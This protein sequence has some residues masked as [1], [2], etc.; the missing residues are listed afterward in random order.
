MSLS[1]VT[2]GNNP[3]PAS[4]G[5]PKAPAT[6]A[7]KSTA[8]SGVSFGYTA[9]KTSTPSAST[10]APVIAPVKPPETKSLFSKFIDS[11][12]GMKSVPLKFPSNGQ[13][14]PYAAPLKPGQAL[15]APLISSNLT[16]ET[17]QKIVDDLN[18][19]ADKLIADGKTVNTKDKNAVDKY[20]ADL[21]KF[22]QDSQNQ[23]GQL[24]QFNMAQKAHE[25]IST[26]KG[27]GTLGP[28]QEQQLERGL[29]IVLLAG[30]LLTG[31]TEGLL[32]TEAIGMGAQGV[33]AKLGPMLAKGI[34][35]GAIGIGVF[36]ALDK[37]MAGVKENSSDGAKL[38]IYLGEIFAAGG[39]LHGLN[40][41]VPKIGD[42]LFQTITEKY[43][44]PKTIF[45]D[46]NKV[47]Q[48]IAHGNMTDADTKALVDAIGGDTAKI[49]AA[50]KNG[51]NIEIPASKIKTIAESPLWTKIKSAFGIK[52]STGESTQIFGKGKETVRGYLNERNEI[53]PTLRTEIRD[54]IDQ[55]GEGVTSVALQDNLGIDAQTAH[56]LIEKAKV[57]INQLE[58]QQAHQQVMQKIAPEK[59]GAL[60][61][62]KITQPK[63]STLDQNQL[64]DK[65]NKAIE[66]LSQ[67]K[68]GEV[69]KALSHPEIGDIDLIWGKEPTKDNKGFGLAKIIDTHPDV[70]P[71]ISEK[72]SQATITEKLPQRT[73]LETKGKNPIR[74][75]IDYQ[76]GEH[77]KVFLNNAYVLREGLEPTT[78][79][80]SR[81]RST[82]ELP[83]HNKSIANENIDVNLPHVDKLQSSVFKRLAAEHPELQGD[84]TYNEMNMKKDAENAVELLA[85]DKEKAFRVAMGMEDAQNVTNTAVNIAMSEQA[86]T[87]GNN[88]LYAQ[89]IKNRSLAQ[90]RRGQEIVAEKGSVTDNST[91]RYV[92]EL[93]NARLELAGKKYLGNIRLTEKDVKISKKQSAQKLIDREVKKVKEKIKSTKELDL[94]EAQK[95]I[96]SLAC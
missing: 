33:S 42:A 2:L 31:A 45:F 4:G 91:A 72:L 23:S 71:H 62:V 67:K 46:G 32:A 19:R 9:P 38:L 16:N 57:P 49:K 18:N 75:I 78:S 52:P 59:T 6:A 96:D 8:L 61:E 82:I 50:F 25:I 3:A 44:A 12:K 34:K 68:E 29:N 56:I 81:E 21:E 47:Q 74:F 13:A 60:G 73:I 40:K 5:N 39:I 83:K 20:N 35:D 88:K 30:G 92:K 63:K 37:A 69:S 54:A 87:E 28:T 48:L 84:V 14:L 55:H 89:L 7:P 26:P 64:V 90:T 66:T 53:N 93:I 80:A 94:A 17:A 27:E 22:R 41:T 51:I 79:P 65:G 36:S 77:P 15:E 10:P 85:T 86:L 76:L 43:N 95:L 1:G 11:V 24:D 58:I 70:I